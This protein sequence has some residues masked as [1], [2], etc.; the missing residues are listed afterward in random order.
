MKVQKSSAFKL[1]ITH[2]ITRGAGIVKLPN[3]RVILKQQHFE[4]S[5]PT[6]IHEW[7]QENFKQ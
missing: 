4:K 6:T 1:L 7:G 3:S 2:V 5:G